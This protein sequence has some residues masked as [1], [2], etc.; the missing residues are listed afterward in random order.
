MDGEFKVHLLSFRRQIARL[1]V[2]RPRPQAASHVQQQDRLSPSV[3]FAPHPFSD[4]SALATG[5]SGR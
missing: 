1:S 5:S 2:A 3:P 4:R